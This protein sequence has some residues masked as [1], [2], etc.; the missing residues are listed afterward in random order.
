MCRYCIAVAAIERILAPALRAAALLAVLGGI[1]PGCAG[2]NAVPAFS[3]PLSAP[4]PAATYLQRLVAGDSLFEDETSRTR[5]DLSTPMRA[6]FDGLQYLLDED[7][8]VQFLG[9]SSDALRSEWL[10]RFWRLRDPTPTTLENERQAEHDRRV[11]YARAHFYWPLPP[12]WDDRGRVYIQF[13]EPTSIGEELPGVYEGSMYVPYRLDWTY[14]ESGW[15]VSFER[16]TPAARWRL[17]RSP[18]P[19]SSRP[20]VVRREKQTLGVD[21]PG[22]LPGDLRQAIAEI[23]PDQLQTSA[24][25]AD[26]LA[27]RGGAALAAVA[28]SRAVV[29]RVDSREEIFARSGA[30]RAFLPYAFDADVFA[31][32]GG[33]SRLEIHFQVDLEDLHFGA[34]DSLFLARYRAEGCLQDAALADVARDAYEETVPARRF[35]TTTRSV[36]WPGQLAF[37][38]P[39]GSYRLAVRLTDLQSGNEGTYVSDVLVRPIAVQSLSISDLE[40]ATSV[41]DAREDLNPRFRKGPHTVVPNA[42]A[43]FPRGRELTAY[44]EIYGL[45]G[46]ADAAR[47][48][49][50]SYAITRRTPVREQ[51][52]FPRPEPRTAPSVTASFN[53]QATAPTTYEALRIDVASLAPDTHDLAVTVYDLQS[54]AEA[55]TNT[56]FRI[57]E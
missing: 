9:L 54:N 13:G 43:V 29:A 14:A 26:E 20:D 38:V 6:V 11:A 48:Y 47:P 7:L 16:P 8:Q 31:G 34:A 44:F 45:G 30:G 10:R 15:T 55:M 24:G 39:A 42:M 5:D 17:G 27:S 23:D 25:L 1:A 19:V 28:Q 37:E 35:D 53:A 36:Q 56:T 21:S 52:W 50:V 22:S 57:L 18:V 51:G 3:G 40:L 4:L 2:E 46:E 49:R 41:L 12:F 33:R 32:T